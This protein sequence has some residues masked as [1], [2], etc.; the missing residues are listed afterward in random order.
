[1]RVTGLIWLTC[2]MTVAACGQPPEKYVATERT[3][4][5]SMLYVGGEG[6]I[7]WYKLDETKGEL[8]KAGSITYPLAATFFAKSADG[9]IFY[10]LLRTINE[11][12]AM[13]EMQPLEGHVA[14]YT[15]DQKTGELKEIGRRS[16]EGDRP[17][18][19]ILDKTG[20]FA[21]VANNLGHIKG[22]SIVVYPVG[23][24]G[25]LGEPVHKIQKTGIRAHQVR[26]DPSNKYVYVPNIDSETVSQYKFDEK[27]GQLTA[28][29]PDAATLP[30][31]DPAA[32]VVMGMDKKVFGPRHL[33]FHPNGK[34]VYLSNEYAANTIAYEIQGNGT[35]KQMGG[36][37]SGVPDGYSM[38]KW[39]SEIRVAPSGKF[40]YAGERVHETLAVYE[41]DQGNGTLK[42]KKNV[43]T[44]GKTPRNFALTP[45]GK[46]LVVGNQESSS[47]VLFK[48]EGDGGD[49]TK[50][51]GPIDQPFPYVHLWLGLP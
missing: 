22:N 48:V 39:Q 20:K 2:A 31:D 11:M 37:V 51:Q 49:L 44:E 13:M 29:D 38:R 46:W 14:T 5:T 3:G 35:L 16:S 4:A 8:Q 36:P 30:P 1:M 23:S 45:S 9:K 50:T 32:A 10:A 28:N 43:A 18:Y 21:L 26:I 17:T 12:K 6:N 24:D 15:V 7:T 25:V 41:V 47:L 40:V 34:W 42:L 27:T 19:I 33:D